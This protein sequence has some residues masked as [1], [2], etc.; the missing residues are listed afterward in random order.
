M[1]P[2]LAELTDDLARQRAALLAAIAAIPAE[3]L[4]RR[5]A[6]DGWS[7]AEVV[8][9][10]SLV[11]SGTA[12]LLAKRAA[13]AREAGCGPETRTDSVRGCMDRWSVVDTPARFQA[14][15]AVR[16]RAGV[17]MEAALGAL[18][19]AREALLA[20]IREVDGLDLTAVT[21]MHP[22][23]GELDAYQ[24]IVSTAQH[25]ARH[26]RQID[27]IAASLRATAA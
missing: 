13:R 17:T 8:D 12:R 16:P 3:D 23:F 27:A 6:P 11:E 22:A 26:L 9:H 1:H 24:W 7:V 25:E 5:A 2:R 20:T 18:Q 10:L 14:P 15:E 19:A 4:E 21:A